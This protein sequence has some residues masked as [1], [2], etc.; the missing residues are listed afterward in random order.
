M[1]TIELNFTDWKKWNIQP[2]WEI[3]DEKIR[4][5]A[6]REFPYAA[7]N[8]AAEKLKKRLIP[9]KKVFEKYIIPRK[10]ADL[11]IPEEAVS[12]AFLHG[13][14]IRTRRTCM[15]WIHFSGSWERIP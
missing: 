12:F 7:M 2:D 6:G 3:T 9:V 11:G 14:E 4:K 8:N 10:A 5:L 13:G 1:Q 15:D